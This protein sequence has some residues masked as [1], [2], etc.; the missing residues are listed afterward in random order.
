MWAY[1]EQ[2]ATEV[3]KDK[4]KKKSRGGEKIL[5]LQDAF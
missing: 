1:S 5:S 4:G 2:Q 3:A